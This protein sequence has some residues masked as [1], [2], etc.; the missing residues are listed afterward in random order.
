MLKVFFFVITLTLITFCGNMHA[1][2]SQDKEEFE[3]IGAD[4]QS[5]WNKHDSKA[6]ASFWADDAN[7]ISNWGKEYNGKAEI[8][9]HFANEHSNGM[10][11]SQFTLVIQNVRFINPDTVF[12]DAD[13]TISGMTVSGE[14]AAPLNDHAVFLLVKRDGKWLILIGRPY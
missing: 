14:K 2:S 1:D 13:T 9:K 6:L 8:E 12:L 7:L 4:F 5:A 3:K 11:D 10:K